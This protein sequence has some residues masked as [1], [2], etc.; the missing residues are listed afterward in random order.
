MHAGTGGTPLFLVH[1][2]A[3]D[4]AWCAWLAEGLDPALPV[5]ALPAVPT[6]LLEHAPQTI[7]GMA[8]RLLALMRAVQPQGPYRIAG[9]SMG[10]VLAH[11][12]AVQLLGQDQPVQFVGLID[13]P[14]PESRAGAAEP[15]SSLQQAL[16][17]LCAQLRR[18]EA[19]DATAQQAL[20][21]LWVQAPGLGFEALLAACVEAGL[22]PQEACEQVEHAR[23]FVQRFAAYRDALSQYA[24]HPLSAPGC[25]LVARDG[26]RAST[27]AWLAMQPPWR[28]HDLPGRLRNSD[29]IDSP[30]AAELGLLLSRVCIETC[31]AAAP[32]PEMHH[33]AHVVIQGGAPGREP[34]LCIPGAGDN[35]TGFIPM[36]AALGADAPVHGLQPRGADGRLAPHTTVEAAAAFYL[37]NLPPALRRTPV[38]LLGHS[39][40]GW[41]AFEMALQRQDRGEPVASLTIVDTEMP[42]GDG[43]LGQE[44]GSTAALLELLRVIEMSSKKLLGIARPAFEAADRASQMQMLHEAM[45]RIGLLP[46]RSDAHSLGGLVRSFGTALRTSYRP[47]R[48]F[49]A[50]RTGLVLAADPGE[51]A[52][53]NH[54]QHRLALEGWRHWAPGLS[55]WMAPGDHFSIL[56]QPHVSALAQWWRDGFGKAQPTPARHGL[57][58]PPGQPGVAA[59]AR[60]RG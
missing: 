50:A 7:E 43:V 3:G 36:A 17:V 21:R 47:R 11:E 46:K 22:L 20:S 32:R 34:V 37:D 57:A 6:T 23:R 30:V 38:H 48:S 53:T 8:R 14:F 31:A 5:Y 52:S 25:L 54:R 2:D 16:L 55:V 41:I 56:K 33:L 49:A 35:V 39:F 51:D 15:A 58:L 40:G 24:V 59:F 42:D 19:L 60:L 44:Y 1:D 28:V 27:Q 9:A 29:A 13:T 12:V 18:D 4:E 10:G 26:E 45:V